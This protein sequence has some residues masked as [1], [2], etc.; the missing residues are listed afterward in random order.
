[1]PVSEAMSFRGPVVCLSP[2]LTPKT[3]AQMCEML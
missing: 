2:G 3:V 1:M